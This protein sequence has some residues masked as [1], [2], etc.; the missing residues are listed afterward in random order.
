MLTQAA[1]PVVFALDEV[2]SQGNPLWGLTAGMMPK[3][4]ED[5]A[6]QP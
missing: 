3:S 5:M 2:I 4:F 1:M 6:S